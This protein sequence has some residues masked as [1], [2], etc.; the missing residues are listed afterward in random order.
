MGVGVRAGAGDVHL[1]IIFEWRWDRLTI[2]E[3]R[4]EDVEAVIDM[5]WAAPFVRFCAGSHIRG[6]LLG[7]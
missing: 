1:L 3:V 4:D 6:L 7:A 2:F 5:F